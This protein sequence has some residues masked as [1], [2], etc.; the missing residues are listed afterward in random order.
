MHTCRNVKIIAHIY[1]KKV[2]LLLCA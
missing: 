1:L 2:G